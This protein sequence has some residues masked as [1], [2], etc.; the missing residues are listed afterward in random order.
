MNKEIRER[1]KRRIEEEED[2]EVNCE[3][4]KCQERRWT[5]SKG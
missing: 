4:E 2:G 5:E 1:E 3:T